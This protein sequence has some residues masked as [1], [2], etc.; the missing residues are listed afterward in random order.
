MHILGS[1]LGLRRAHAFTCNLASVVWGVPSQMEAM[2]RSTL[3]V[4]V[5]ALSSTGVRVVASLK[6]WHYPTPDR[7]VLSLKRILKPLFGDCGTGAYA[8]DRQIRVQTHIWLETFCK[9]SWT[10]DEVFRPSSR[11]LAAGYA[12]VPRN[13]PWWSSEIR[14]EAGMILPG[15]LF[16]LITL[17]W[18]R[19][20][21]MEQL[22]AKLIF[23]A[24]L[25]RTLTSDVLVDFV[26]D[27]ASSFAD[28]HAQC[29]ARVHGRCTHQQRFGFDRLFA[30]ARFTEQLVSMGRSSFCCDWLACA[31]RRLLERLAR[32]V[33]E[34]M[35]RIARRGPL[36]EQHLVVGRRKYLD[37]D[38][39]E[40]VARQAQT[41]DARDMEAVTSADA[42]VTHSGRFVRRW[43]NAGVS[44][45]VASCLRH[46]RE[47]VRGVHS[48]VED[49]ARVGNPGEETLVYHH[50][51]CASG[52]GHWL[53]PQVPWFANS[54]SRLVVLPEPFFLLWPSHCIVFKGGVLRVARAIA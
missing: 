28:I 54:V 27:L 36:K 6:A 37:D 52:V 26:G 41:S 43:R 49:A 5:S 20:R 48:V 51:N 17:A 32:L 13:M 12:D 35:L 9:L 31:L 7:C 39:R 16:L 8:A 30:H 3:Y 10:W 14:D 21:S 42:S 53:L 23:Q 24:M 34:G 25:E 11:A 1:C 38:Y 15:V 44:R 29:P 19:R 50:Y 45:H 47:G 4:D 22:R 46:H 33:V 2:E 40:A 18:S